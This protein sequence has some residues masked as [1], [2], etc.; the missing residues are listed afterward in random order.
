[1]VTQVFLYGPALIACVKHDTNVKSVTHNMFVT[2]TK[3]MTLSRCVTCI[4]NTKIFTIKPPTVWKKNAFIFRQRVDNID[5][6]LFLMIFYGFIDFEGLQ[7]D[8]FL[9]I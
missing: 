3:P 2:H 1:M 4:N 7:F 5:K 8:E 6:I 9:K